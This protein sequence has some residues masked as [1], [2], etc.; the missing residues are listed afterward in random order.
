MYTINARSHLSTY[1]ELSHTACHR[2]F[3]D[4]PVG[5]FG[6]DL[7][8]PGSNVHLLLDTYRKVDLLVE[9]G[10]LIDIESV[11]QTVMDVREH[12]GYIY[13]KL[14]SR[15]FV[16]D[17]YSREA[18]LHFGASIE[19]GAICMPALLCEVDQ[20]V[21]NV[22]SLGLDIKEDNSLK[23]M[24]PGFFISSCIM[25]D[26]FKC[27]IETAGYRTD[28]A[29]HTP[30]LRFI[31]LLGI[32]VDYNSPRIEIDT[33]KSEVQDAFMSLKEKSKDVIASMLQALT[34][35]TTAGNDIAELLGEEPEK[36][37]TS[38]L[39]RRLELGS[40][41]DPLTHYD[42]DY[43]AE[44]NGL[45]YMKPDGS[46]GIYK[47]PSYAWS[48]FEKIA[49]YISKALL[50][51][52]VNGRYLS[53]GCG[54]GSDVSAFMQ[55]GW[56]AVGI[57]LSKDAVQYGRDKLHLT[58]AQ[59]VLGDFT[60]VNR[61]KE[62]EGRHELVVSYD[63]LE[64]IWECDIHSIV[65]DILSYVAVGGY[66][67]HDVCT[68]FENE[69]DFVA[70]RG[71]CFSVDNSALLCSGHV[72]IREWFYWTQI[73]HEVAERMGITLE[74]AWEEYGLFNMYMAQD[75]VLSNVKSWSPKNI[76]FF[77]RIA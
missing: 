66:T 76:L 31:S 62:I 57:D 42:K 14:L 18:Y 17:D 4:Y 51:N 11:E 3:A 37:V 2:L 53:L 72:N 10:T 24:D 27:S 77:K 8:E 48:G 75:P 38:N 39:P 19:E 23:L 12:I 74:F 22:H 44:G 71:V 34:S 46:Q 45:A 64:H 20:G 60:A 16:G 54:A 29:T 25:K 33:S 15:R 32:D 1:G 7:L 40:V 73:F 26:V 59:L 69:N 52:K 21:A 67:F 28:F 58:T 13:T 49:G 70:E 50:P 36:V 56:K 68:R 47:G 9:L 41:F 61:P 35:T 63:F 5:I 30:L 65:G 55:M 6:L 43:Y